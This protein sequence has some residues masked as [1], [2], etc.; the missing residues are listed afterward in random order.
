MAELARHQHDLA[1]VM[2]FMSD[3]VSQHMPYIEW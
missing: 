2:A 1:T 3:E